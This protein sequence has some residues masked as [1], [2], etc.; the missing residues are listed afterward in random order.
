MTY[1]EALESIKRTSNNTT[2]ADTTANSTA[3]SNTDANN[4][5]AIVPGIRYP[6]PRLPGTLFNVSI[7]SGTTVNFRDL[8]EMSTPGGMSINFR[9]PFLGNMAASGFQN[10]TPLGLM[11]AFR[12]AG[13]TIE[14]INN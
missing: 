1:K 5:A 6:G 8:F 7:P 11:N 12:A 14:V 2:A 3:A 9:M 10:F 13:G 4:S